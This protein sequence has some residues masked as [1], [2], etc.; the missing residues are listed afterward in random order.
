[1]D[2][3]AGEMPFLDHLEELRGRIIRALIAVI[4][5][6]SAGL[7]VVTNYDA[8]GY[9]KAPIAPY[10]PGGKLTIL[11]PTEQV[12]VVLKLGVVIGLVLASPV[13]IYQIWA[14][15]SPALYAKEKK[16]M[17]PALLLGLLLFLAGGWLG[18]YYGVPLSLKF[19]MNFSPENFI[20]QITFAEYF[21]FVVQVVLAV[22]ISFEL[23]LIMTLLSWLG[24]MDA[25][26]FSSFRRYAI[27]LNCIAGAVLS[28]GTD[29]FS[30]LITS[31]MLLMLY[32]LG[33]L[34][35][36]VVQ[37][38]KRKAAAIGAMILFALLAG[39]PH[40]AQ[41]QNP[42]VRRPTSDSAGK[43]RITPGQGTRAIDS[44]TAKRLGLPSEPKRKFVEPDSV[45]QALLK[46][47]GFAV[48]RFRGDSAIL[49]PGDEGLLLGGRAATK[50]DTSTLE[51]D[52][53]IYSDA[54]CELS[55]KGEPQMFEGGRAGQILIGRTMKF[56]TCQERGVIGEALTTFDDGGGNWFL[57]GN[58]AVDSTGKRLYASHSEFTSCDQPEPH[59]HFQS[60]QVKWVSQSV[61][62]AR[63]AVLYIRDVPIVWLPFLFQ[64]T[65]VGR[66]SGILIP[67][68]GF[69]DIVRPSRTYN[70]QVTNIGYYWAPNDYIDATVHLDWFANRYMQYGGQFRYRWRDRFVTGDLAIDKQ[71]QSEG[72]GSTNIR[73]NHNQ[74]FNVTTSLRVGFNYVGSTSVLQGNTVDPLLS[75]QQITSTATLQKRF[76]WGTTSLGATRNQTIS[77]GSVRMTLPSLDIT[78]RPFEFGQHVTWSP[79]ISFANALEQQITRPLE[80]IVSPGR[81]DTLLAK[82]SS[83][84]TTINI[85]TPIRFGTFTWT[86]SLAYTDRLSTQRTQVIQ[87]VPDQSTPDPNDSITV[88]TIRAADF[89]S[90]VEWNTGINL[91]MLFQQTFK[92]QPVL[93]ITNVTPNGA[94]MVRN[95]ATRGDWVQQGKKLRLSLS[96]GPQLFGFLSGFGPVERFRHNLQPTLA[97]QY[98]PKAR[99]N[100]AYANAVAGST[101]TILPL[102]TPPELTASFGLNQTLTAKMRKAPSDTTTDDTNRP[103]P[104]LLQ[105]STSSI[106]YDFEQAKLPGRTGWT[107]QALNNSLQSDLIRGF[108]LSLTHDLWEGQVGTDTAKFAPFLSNVNASM[109][110]TG[111]TFKSIGAFL[112]LAKRRDPSARPDTTPPPAGY[113]TPSSRRFRPGAFNNTDAFSGGAGRGFTM[114]VNYSLQ[115]RRPTGTTVGSVSTD[116]ND[117][118]FPPTNLVS[119]NHSNIGLSTSF[120]PTHN[121][122]VS[123]STQY[124]IT[125]SKF[126]S[127]QIRLQRDLHDW[128]ASFDF[129]KTATGNFAFFF[130]V[131][132]KPLPDVKFDYNQTTLTPR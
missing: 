13:I 82:G 21:S 47:E 14:F 125:D 22:G 77:D 69:N 42:P 102:E 68:F 62:V 28:P 105:L 90:S 39:A 100:E 114:N 96:M 49:L 120:S 12:M 95:A 78:P 99:L 57:R 56:D 123:W 128:M 97:L 7:W 86:N 34:G 113:M 33:V 85:G 26:K 64:D 11:Q 27:L 91:P 122:S 87:R 89:F 93:G 65:K 10:L 112:G 18:W 30:M 51:A 60:G 107:T 110:L 132:L 55:A 25:K 59:Y 16:A 45:M 15:L 124:N 17:I 92:I 2:K 83:R 115:R 119:G 48:T 66:R 54:R 101:G 108:Q 1:M 117:I 70:R 106:A 3:S 104:I 111:A 63:P 80:F 81:V 127:Q 88:N 24:V 98:S 74:Q 20:S 35:A 131:T 129:S 23:P 41:A 52:E 109:A 32:E 118:F 44:A 19:L 116:P 61:L 43:A 50:R 75:T 130:T 40:E 73:W 126:E 38:R 4:A 46:R 103:K 121:W 58:L 94:F 67:N 29:V 5:G 72:G 8:I 37:R 76:R 53:I 31:A 71:Q 36:F 79:N 84:N 6:V 9:L